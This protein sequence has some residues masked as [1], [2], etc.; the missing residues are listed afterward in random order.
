MPIG[1]ITVMGAEVSRPH[2]GGAP[3]PRTTGAFLAVPV[4][5]QP[6]HLSKCAAQLFIPRPNVGFRGDP[7]DPTEEPA[8]A[9]DGSGADVPADPR[10]LQPAAK[11]LQNRLNRIRLQ[12][13]PTHTRRLSPKLSLV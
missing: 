10:L 7:P 5:C 12:G 13:L 8:G 11:T 9:G 1:N 3:A 4:L 6:L 2:T